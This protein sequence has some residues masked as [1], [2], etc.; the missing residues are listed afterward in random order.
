MVDANHCH[1]DGGRVVA[2]RAVA[3]AR[4]VGRRDRSS[5]YGSR[6]GDGGHRGDAH[7]VGAVHSKHPEGQYDNQQPYAGCPQPRRDSRP[8][9]ESSTVHSPDLRPPVEEGSTAAATTKQTIRS[10]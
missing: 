5:G 10:R 2:R 6:C 8:R 1:A 4:F 3:P 9:V 7:M